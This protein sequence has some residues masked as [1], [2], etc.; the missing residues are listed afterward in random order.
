M[1]KVKWLVVPYDKLREVA[2]SNTAKKIGD[3]D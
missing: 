1:S 3:A 2:T